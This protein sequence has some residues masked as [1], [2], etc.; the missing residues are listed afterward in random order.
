M[1]ENRESIDIEYTALYEKVMKK[2]RQEDEEKNGGKNRQKRV[3]VF[4]RAIF[5]QNG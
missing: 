1:F 4:A 3:A 5:I 2:T